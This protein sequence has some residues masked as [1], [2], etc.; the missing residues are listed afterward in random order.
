MKAKLIFDLNDSDD[1]ES[2]NRCNKSLDMACVLFEISA[3]LRRKVEN[4]VDMEYNK[5]GDINEVEIVY[6]EINKLFETFGID[7]E[8]LIS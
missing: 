6:D 8:K 2:F 3:N 4:K 1:R 5:G 7:I